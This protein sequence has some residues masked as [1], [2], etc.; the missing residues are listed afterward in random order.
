MTDPPR[1]P[2]RPLHLQASSTE[3][4]HPWGAI[5]SESIHSRENTTAQWQ[6]FL[7]DAR[8]TSAMHG[9]VGFVL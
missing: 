5:P 7:S 1:G 6:N 3:H 4:Y 8:G 9:G 2:P